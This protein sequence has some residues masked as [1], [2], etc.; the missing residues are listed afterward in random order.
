MP[1]APTLL[2]RVEIDRA[3]DRLVLRFHTPRAPRVVLGLFLGFFLAGWAAGLVAVVSMM[4]A[5]QVDGRAATV[6]GMWLV[7]WAGGGLFA[8]WVLFRSVLATEVVE[9]DGTSLSVRRVLG[10][11][12]F[13]TPYELRRIRN[14]RH[15]APGRSSRY[16]FA[17]EHAGRTL[18]FG[19][20]VPAGEAAEVLA[21]VRERFPGA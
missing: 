13:G 9:V 10:P 17:F 15:D 4:A 16:S 7:V 20:G 12:G 1:D 18:R 5:G 19:P 8:F 3:P 14:L 11:V 21:A 2:T 6:A